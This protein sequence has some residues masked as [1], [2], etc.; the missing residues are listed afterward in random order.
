MMFWLGFFC[1][2]GSASTAALIVLA[3]LLHGDV[4][5]EDVAEAE[6]VGG[7]QHG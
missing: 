6:M 4:R 5:A 1:G 2:L 7:A 3:V